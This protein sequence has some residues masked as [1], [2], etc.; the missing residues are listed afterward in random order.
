ML[1]EC[2]GAAV[3]EPVVGVQRGD[4]GFYSTESCGGMKI[5]GPACKRRRFRDKPQ[6]TPCACHPP[7]LSHQNSRNLE[8]STLCQ[9]L[10]KRAAARCHGANSRA[11]HPPGAIFTIS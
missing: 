9:A 7:C 11:W 6:A 4:E 5:H 8:P 3:C 10:E 1:R 2:A